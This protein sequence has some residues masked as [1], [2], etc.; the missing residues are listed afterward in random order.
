MDGFEVAAGVILKWVGEWRVE[1]EV[2]GRTVVVEISS[3]SVCLR[4][5]GWLVGWLTIDWD[6]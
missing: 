6:M 5:D 3:K 2:D 1:L 4:L